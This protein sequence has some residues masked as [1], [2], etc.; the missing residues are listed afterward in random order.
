M[1]YKAVFNKEE[2]ALKFENRK[3]SQSLLQSE[4]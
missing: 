4:A 2:Y 3:K 1:I